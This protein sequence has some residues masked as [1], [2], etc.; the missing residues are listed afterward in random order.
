MI[1]AVYSSIGEVSVNTFTIFARHRISSALAA[2][3]S[4]VSAL[5]KMLATM[6]TKK[7]IDI[8]QV[9]HRPPVRLQRSMFYFYQMERGYPSPFIGRSSFASANRPA[10]W[11]SR[12]WWTNIFCKYHRC[13]I[14]IQIK[15]VIEKMRQ[16]TINVVSSVT[17]ITPYPCLCPLHNSPFNHL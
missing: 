2:P 8:L 12:R 5:A 15:A 7:E 17:T 11:Q 1:S 10:V 4:G 16:I 6:D 9:L 3:A 14:N 13:L